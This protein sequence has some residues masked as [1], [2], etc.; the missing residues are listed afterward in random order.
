MADS[1]NLKQVMAKKFKINDGSRGFV[2]ANTLLDPA[3]DAA[4]K[5]HDAE[6]IR[7]VSVQLSQIK[8]KHDDANKMVN[9][10][11]IDL[12]KVQ[13][14]IWAL[15]QQEI[16]AEGPVYQVKTRKE[17][18]EDALQQS[19]T[20]IDEEMM[21]QSTYRHMLERMKKD[22]IATRIRSSEQEISLKS[23]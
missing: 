18:L 20:K 1:S 7:E 8:K 9:Q 3:N 6:E 2:E 19:N 4:A 5:Q 21:T 14:E 16:H 22:F 23:K 17:Q 15:E 10:K 12:E 11:K 13:K